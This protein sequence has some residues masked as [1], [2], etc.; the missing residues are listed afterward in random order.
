MKSKI[1]IQKYQGYSSFS[2]ISDQSLPIILRSFTFRLVTVFTY[3]YIDLLLTFIDI[4]NQLIFT[5]N[6]LRAIKT[7]INFV[8]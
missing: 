6:S 8:A 3:T 2:I 4:T 7:K 5:N 1:L